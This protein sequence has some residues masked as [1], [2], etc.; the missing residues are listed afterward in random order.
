MQ[1][2]LYHTKKR[3]W[4]EMLEGAFSL[5]FR[6]YERKDLLLDKQTGY[7]RFL[8]GESPL[9]VEMWTCLTRPLLLGYLVPKKINLDVEQLENNKLKITEQKGG[10]SL[11]REYTFEED[12]VTIHSYADVIEKTII[13]PVYN[14]AMDNLDYECTIITEDAT[15]VK[16]FNVRRDKKFSNE[17]IIHEYFG[18]ESYTESPVKE[19]LLAFGDKKYR[20]TTEEKMYCFQ[21][22]NYVGFKFVKPSEFLNEDVIKENALIELGTMV[23]ERCI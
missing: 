15:V 13:E 16:K 6:N 21:Q 4:A 11:H 19:V 23:I 2:R 18:K 7:L 9:F 12:K 10:Y 20:I 22:F 17:E 3:F 5:S 14:I 8:D 1:L